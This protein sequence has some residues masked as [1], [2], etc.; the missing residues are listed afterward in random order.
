MPV[1]QRLDPSALLAK[2]MELLERYEAEERVKGG[3]G[4]M[5]GGPG[6]PHGGDRGYP[7]SSPMFRA[8]GELGPRLQ[9]VRSAISEAGHGMGK[10]TLE[11]LE[12]ALSSQCLRELQVHCKP[13][14]GMGQ[15]PPRQD[16]TT[17]WK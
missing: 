9:E 17:F 7:Q 8:V 4:A 5:T 14:A 2:E 12:V 11:E 10:M 13:L 3:E 16:L 15:V 6:G 1:Y